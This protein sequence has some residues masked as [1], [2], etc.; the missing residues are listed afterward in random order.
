MRVYSSLSLPPA[1]YLCPR[2]PHCVAFKYIYIHTD[3]YIH[4]YIYRGVKRGFPSRSI[5]SQ[6]RDTS[7]FH[8]SPLQL[9][10]LFFFFY[11]LSSHL[12]IHKLL[13]LTNASALAR[14]ILFHTNIRY[15]YIYAR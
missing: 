3:I 9:F 1:I 5:V 4:I 7:L 2:E 15:T 10:F 14:R 13:H 8:S 12:H 6:C 11:F